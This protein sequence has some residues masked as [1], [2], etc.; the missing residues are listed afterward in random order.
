MLSL[1]KIFKPDK[2]RLIIS[3]VVAIAV[4]IFGCLQLSWYTAVGYSALFFAA[5]CCRIKVRRVKKCYTLHFIW[6]FLLVLATCL[7]PYFMVV[8]TYFP[9][10]PIYKIIINI[11]FIY[12]FIG[13]LFLITS[14]TRSVFIGCLILAI[15]VSINGFIFEFRGK[16]LSYA[17]FLS[18]ATAIN[19]AGQYKPQIHT[20]MAFGWLGWLLIAYIGRCMPRLPRFPK[21]RARIFVSPILVA[22]IIFVGVSSI[23]IPVKTWEAEATRLNGFY[24]NF[25]LGI[26][27]SFVKEPENYSSEAIEDRAKDGV[28]VNRTL[29]NAPNVI[30]VM[31]ESF[32]DFRIIGDLRTNIPVT[33]FLDSLTENTIRGYALSSV[34]GG[35]TANSEFEVLTAHTLSFLPKDS[36]PYQQYIND[37]IYTL[38]WLMK[39]FGYK[40]VSTHPYY[41][42]GWSRN[43]IYPYM[44]FSE[45]TFIESY[46]PESVI[47]NYISDQAVFDYIINALN[48]KGDQPLFMHSVT[49]QNHGG[50]DFEGEN[51]TQTVELLDYSKEYPLAEQYLTVIN[52]TDTAMQNF[53]N[54]LENFEED[55]VVLFFGD[56]YPKVESAFYDELHGG[57]FKTLDEK[58]LKYTVPFI[59][60][61]NY[62]IDEQLVGCT[63]LNYL[64]RY[65]LDAAKIPLPP[66]YRFLSELEKVIPAISAQGYYSLAQQKFIPRE[67]AADME[68]V[69]LNH[70]SLLQYNN[71]FDEKHRSQTLFGQFLPEADEKEAEEEIPTEEAATDL[72]EYHDEEG[73]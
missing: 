37:N 21:K 55:T 4:L 73:E 10:T 44:G 3:A 27:D 59:I 54:A 34:Y 15:F 26:R 51:F 65:L 7:L 45:S 33:P 17:D 52:H 18:I 47:R 70:Y 9:N 71:L 46:P 69:W 39:S 23:N 2:K 12:S 11:V 35:K 14:K 32:V 72:P 8:S 68:K 62:D 25:I 58:M 60:W 20:N 50:Y 57:S 22:S 29:E 30:I 48:T 13:L 1:K 31:D 43:R 36:V 41:E 64:S 53:I 49:M 61:A 63:S 19:V 24:L 66:Y 5:G 6:V 28:P 56:H 16:E 38:A 40:S 67:D 42:N